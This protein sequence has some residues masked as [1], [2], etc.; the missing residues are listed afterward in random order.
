MEPLVHAEQPAKSGYS[1]LSAI[2]R[3]SPAAREHTEPARLPWLVSAE[4]PAYAV[5]DWLHLRRYVR[6]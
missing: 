4:R 6:S 5:R 1:K 3:D 2:Q